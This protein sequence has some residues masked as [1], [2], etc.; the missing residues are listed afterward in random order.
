ML[1]CCIWLSSSVC[2]VCIVAKRCVLEQTLL[3]PAY[4][5]SYMRNRLVSKLMT[6]T[7]LGVESRSCQQLRCIQRSL[8]LKPLEIEAWF[9][10]TANRKW[11]MGYQMWC[12]AVTVSYPNDSLASFFYFLLFLMCHFVVNWCDKL[13]FCI[14]I[15]CFIAG[16]SY[17]TRLI[18][19]QSWSQSRSLNT[20]TR[21]ISDA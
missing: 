3:L 17:R 11:P 15:C 14:Y 5:K 13:R 19:K 18:S 9:Q 1:Q 10:R 2:D 8:S 4:S 16:F 21:L 6:L 12:E 20:Y 7:F